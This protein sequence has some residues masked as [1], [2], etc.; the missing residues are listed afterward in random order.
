MS[1][2]WKRQ[3][4]FISRDTKKS[5]KR[6]KRCFLDVRFIAFLSEIAGSG[7]LRNLRDFVETADDQT[8]ILQSRK[9][10][11]GNVN[12]GLEIDWNLQFL[13]ICPDFA[14]QRR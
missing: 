7:V 2:Y 5:T 9:R 11:K 6:A 8:I 1:G 10:F 13:G 4:F 3:L 12:Q 14:E